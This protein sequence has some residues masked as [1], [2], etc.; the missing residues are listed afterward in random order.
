[1][2]VSGGS[3][4][5]FRSAFSHRYECS[6]FPFPRGFFC[7]SF[8]MLSEL[9]GGRLLR[10]S[11]RQD[12]GVGQIR[13]T[14]LVT[15]RY[16]IFLFTRLSSGLKKNTFACVFSSRSKGETLDVLALFPITPVLKHRTVKTWIEGQCGRRLHS[17]IP[18]VASPTVAAL[19]A[20]YLFCLA[21]TGR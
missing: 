2:L 15:Y 20:V 16:H 21:S 11:P 18:V 17:T 9:V 1:M 12:V 6:C 7:A 13:F 4:S 10:I 14:V 5:F 19:D 8:W 3:V